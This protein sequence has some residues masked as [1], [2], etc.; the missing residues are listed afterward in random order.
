MRIVPK[1]DEQYGRTNFGRFDGTGGSL[2]TMRQKSSS[3]KTNRYSSEYEGA[4]AR[5]MSNEGIPPQSENSNLEKTLRY[6][7][8]WLVLMLWPSLSLATNCSGQDVMGDSSRV[9]IWPRGE[10]WKSSLLNSLV[11][12]SYDV[13]K[14]ALMQPNSPQRNNTNRGEMI[15]NPS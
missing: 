12:D 4:R 9:T 8:E 1:V 10:P 11:F 2:H 14:V 3:M 7:V 6:P 15:V 13:K 5:I